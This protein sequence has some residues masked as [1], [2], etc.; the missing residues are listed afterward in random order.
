MSMLFEPALPVESARASFNAD[1]TGWRLCNYPYQLVTHYAAFEN[2]TASP[3]YA[4][5]LENI[6]PKIDS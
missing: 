1:Q 5:K 2:T 6:L 4:M 3:V